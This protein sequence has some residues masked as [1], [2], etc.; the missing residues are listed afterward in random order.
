MPAR[1]RSRLA[2]ASGKDVK[3]GEA[4]LYRDGIFWVLRL[5]W[6]KK[7]R[8]SLLLRAERCVS[9]PGMS[10]MASCWEPD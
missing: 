3:G 10:P 8:R 7:A 4:Y 1:H 6:L 9:Y 5:F 2:E